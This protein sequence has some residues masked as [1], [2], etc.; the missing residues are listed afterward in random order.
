MS[1]FM[2]LPKNHAGSGT[3]RVWLIQVTI[4]DDPDGRGMLVPLHDL[5]LDVLYLANLL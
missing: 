4:G 3:G 2:H 5:L 1:P